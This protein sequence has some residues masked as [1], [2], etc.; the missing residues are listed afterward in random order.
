MVH[1]GSLF[2]IMSIYACGGTNSEEPKKDVIL[3]EDSKVDQDT[4]K[5]NFQ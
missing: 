5:E 1:L 4:P 2:L 3:K